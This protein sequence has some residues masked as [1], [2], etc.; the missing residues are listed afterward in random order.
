MKFVALVSGGKDS[1]FNIL[2]CLKQGHELAALANLHPIDTSEQ[3]L[4]SFMFQTVGHDI[5]AYYDRCTG[6]PLFRQPIR[7]NSSK[8][9]ELNYTCTE[10]DEIEDLFKLLSDVKEKMPDIEGVSVGAILSSYQRTRVEDV[11][12]RLNLT[13][14]S[15]LWQRDQLE[16]MKEMCLMSK[17][18]STSDHAKMDARIIKVAAVGL[19][20]TSLNQSLPQML[21]KLKR[22][23][24]IYD[25]HI[26][27]EGG[28]FET[29]V[30]DAPFFSEGSLNVVSHLPNIAHSKD[31]VFS[32][33]L[34]IEFNERKNDLYLE[35]YLKELPTP[36]M[37]NEKWMDLLQHLK[38]L[39]TLP[40]D[41]GINTLDLSTT[42]P[43]IS[44]EVSVA[45]LKDVLYIS[46]IRARDVSMNVQE[47]ADDV[48]LQLSSILETKKI[49]PSQGLYCSLIISDMSHFAQINN[50]YSQFFSVKKYGPLPP[51]RACVGST[52]LGA[53]FL[54]QLSVIFDATESYAGPGSTIV[55]NRKKDGLHVQGRSYWAPC[56]IGPYSQAIWSFKDP[57]KVAYVSGQIALDPP[58]ME[59]LEK[60]ANLQTVVSLRHFDT[61]KNTINAE[62]QL[63]LTCY[64]VDNDVVPSII[65][66]WSLYCGEMAD[67]SEH[68]TDKQPDSIKSLIIVIVSE[69]PRK[70]LC[71]WTGV[72]CEDLVYEDEESYVDELQE[73]GVA[74]C[75]KFIFANK[76]QAA[77]ELHEVVV[78]NSRGKRYFITGFADSLNELLIILKSIIIEYKVTLYYNPRSLQK[79]KI[80]LDISSKIEWYPVLHVYDNKGTSR[81]FGFHVMA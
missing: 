69:I 52:C 65:G 21:P 48:F 8:N 20:Q 62:R 74:E 19:D 59:M 22:L 60:D 67:V 63:L 32:T 75:S 16:L 25:V 54:L 46:N 76:P 56:N 78:T 36:P 23:N 80:P 51:A 27:G 24:E 41:L 7:P 77:R 47:Q 37:L 30:V 70:A 31:G 44:A 34:E 43:S 18:D 38:E 17:Q 50:V 33:Q 2:H 55:S 4:D 14:L 79:N 5:V 72:S 49:A 81:M 58:T 66:T 64:T 6:L 11:C 45:Q 53:G 1:C 3:E 71:E 15:Y 39:K 61:L 13:A 29:L 9:V 42:K 40:N 68:W 35:E 26:C 73:E 10:N 57:N 12:A 28:E